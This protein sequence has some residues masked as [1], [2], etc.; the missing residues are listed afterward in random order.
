MV[1]IEIHLAGKSTAISADFGLFNRLTGKPTAI[2][3][4]FPDFARND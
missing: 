4:L 3:A 1:P 2:S